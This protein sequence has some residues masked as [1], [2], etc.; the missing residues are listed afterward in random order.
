MQISSDEDSFRLYLH[1]KT[2]SPDNLSIVFP[3]LLPGLNWLAKIDVH[4][5][6][7]VEMHDAFHV[8]GVKAFSELAG[9]VTELRD[10][11]RF[12]LTRWHGVLPEH[13]LVQDLLHNLQVPLV[14]MP[15]ATCNHFR[16]FLVFH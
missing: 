3:A 5:R 14:G 15:N 12:G 4:V 6:I 8:A 16:Q 9:N 11:F 10:I 13:L 7:S 2:A 1:V